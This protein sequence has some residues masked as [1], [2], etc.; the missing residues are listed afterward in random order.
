MWSCRNP[1]TSIL[2]HFVLSTTAPVLL[3][4]DMMTGHRSAALGN[5]AVIVSAEWKYDKSEVEGRAVGYSSFQTEAPHRWLHMI[6]L[7]TV[8]RL[9]HTLC[10]SPSLISPALNLDISLSFCFLPFLKL[11]HLQT[12][13]ISFIFR[14][15]GT[16]TQIPYTQACGLLGQITLAP[17]HTH[18][19][20][21][22]SIHASNKQLDPSFN[23]HIWG[24]LDTHV[25]VSQQRGLQ[26]HAEE[27]VS[28]KVMWILFASL[29][30]ND[31]SP[32]YKKTVSV[33]TCSH[34]VLKLN[35][36]FLLW[37]AQ[38]YESCLSAF[39]V[40]MKA[41]VFTKVFFYYD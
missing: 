1:L 18:H 26:L 9:P 6:H 33:Y 7:T 19:P 20:G 13:Y 27:L 15:I 12:H 4:S 2:S 31:S 8:C 41:N 25:C 14:C 40:H 11:P 29:T 39:L 35:D 21:I 23:G 37:N 16:N 3:T 28:H 36:S 30:W 10:L 38:Y 22:K 17:T 32:K 24:L 34:V 5:C